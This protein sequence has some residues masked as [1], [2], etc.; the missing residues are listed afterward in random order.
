MSTSRV[1]ISAIRCGSWAVSASCSSASR[2]RSAANRRLPGPLMHLAVAPSQLVDQLPQ[3]LRQLG[4]RAQAL[5]QP[6]ADGIA[7]RAGCL[8]IDWF[9]IAAILSIHGWSLGAFHP[10]IF[11]RI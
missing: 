11:A 4:F 6:V 5:L 9:V 10:A 8:V 1:W 3:R 7:D 2:S